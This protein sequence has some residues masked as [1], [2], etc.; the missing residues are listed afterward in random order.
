M[1][2]PPAS[3]LNIIDVGD[4][5]DVITVTYVKSK[6]VPKLGV[7]SSWALPSGPFEIRFRLVSE[8]DSVLSLP[9]PAVVLTCPIQA[10]G[11]M[12]LTETFIMTSSSQSSGPQTFTRNVNG[13]TRVACLKRSTGFGATLERWR[14]DDVTLRLSL[15][16]VVFRGL[17]DRGVS[18]TL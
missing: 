16:W 9:C 17:P 12:T 4:T 7:R 1:Q 18:F 6:L 15:R 3:A 5:F 11:T 10:H 14:R 2:S 13:N 8:N